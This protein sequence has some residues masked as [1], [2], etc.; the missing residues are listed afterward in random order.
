M[1]GSNRPAVLFLLVWLIF[2]GTASAQFKENFTYRGYFKDLRAVS[3]DANGNTL[4]QNLFHHRINFRYNMKHNFV[5]GLELRNRAFYGEFLKYAKGYGDQLEYDPGLVDLSWS[6]I[7]NPAFIA[8][9]AIDRVW[10]NWSNDKWDVRL[11]RQ[12]INWGQNLVWNPNDLFN[13]LNYA[14]FDYEE[15][16]GSDAV[17]VERYFKKGGSL[18]MAYKFTEK[19][20][21][22]VMA[23]MYRFNK[24]NYDFQILAGQYQEDVAAGVGWAGNIKGAGFKGEATWFEP[25]TD[26]SE[27]AFLTSATIDIVLDKGPYIMISGLFNTLGTSDLS[28]LLQLTPTA[29]GRL[30]VKRLM[31]N[32]YSVFVNG[33]GA[34]SPLLNANLAAIGAIDIGGIFLMPSIDYSLKTNLDLSLV[35]QSFVGQADNKWQ[36]LSSAVFL[37]I[38][39]SY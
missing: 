27:Q 35:G 3:I 12:R 4:Q 30:D 21:D 16:P 1:S 8:H 6:W 29:G 26:S 13:V 2:G 9:T 18:Q 36:N 11:G 24:K 32:K 33:G 15:R 19:P 7:N 23:L 5:G 39:W 17:K 31:P 10:L 37:R 20:E 34:I 25:M 14:D 22:R 38:K 28:K